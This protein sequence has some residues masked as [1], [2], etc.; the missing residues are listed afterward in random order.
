MRT[1]VESTASTESTVDSSAARA[2]L[3]SLMQ[4]SR[5]FLTAAASSL[6]PSLNWT[7]SRSRMV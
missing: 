4:C 2:D 1:V 6:V 3:G 5:V 7:P